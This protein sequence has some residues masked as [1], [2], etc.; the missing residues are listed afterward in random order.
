MTYAKAYKAITTDDRRALSRIIDESPQLIGES[1]DFPDWPDST[2]LEH[3]IWWRRE[4]M[5]RMLV[6]AGAAPD[7]PGGSPPTTP[8]VRALGDGVDHLARY[9]GPAIDFWTAAGLGDRNGVKRRLPASR[10]ETRQ[11]FRVA[12]LNGQR[13]TAHLLCPDGWFNKE[14][15]VEVL[16]LGRH[17]L[18]WDQGE[19]AW[20]WARE[21]LRLAD[22][23]NITSFVSLDGQGRTLADAA[24]SSG[25]ET[26]VRLVSQ[27]RPIKPRSVE[28]GRAWRPKNSVLQ[29]QFMF[30]CQWAQTTRVR[31]FLASEPDLVHTRTYWGM[32]ALYLPGAYGSEGSVESAL[33]L[34]D[35]GARPYDGISGPSWWGAVEMVLALLDRGV[36]PEDRLHRDSGLLSAAAAT[37]W[38]EPDNAKKWLPVIEGLVAAGGDPNMANIFGR[39]PWGMAHDT[40]R[41][42]LER[43]GADPLPH[44]PGLREFQLQLKN[45]IEEAVH[46]AQQDVELLEIYDDQESGCTPA[47]DLLL[48]GERAVAEHLISQKKRIDINEAAA[49]GNLDELSRCLDEMEFTGPRAGEGHKGIP[50]HLAAW[51][52]QHD[53]IELLLDRGYSPFAENVADE[54]GD[55]L[56]IANLRETTPLNAAAEAGQEAVVSRF[57]DLWDAHWQ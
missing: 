23:V 4:E 18:T 40:V 43:L 5:V 54:A 17:L 2:L 51:L 34:L 29:E 55:Y 45:D 39:T 22:P 49:F 3:A 25:R 41:P 9:L 8:L 37:R 47:V 12:C 46:T 35:A 48:R 32:G 50:L 16:L 13:E 42:S 33:T 28:P 1:A 57:L 19:T 20:D 31:E 10:D 24:N 11:A 15:L 27:R 21:Q 56:G 52:G 7:R 30:A 44:H 38:N 36:V 26:L 53:A 6:T 14:A